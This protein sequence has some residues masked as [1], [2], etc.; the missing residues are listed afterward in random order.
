MLSKFL[1]VLCGL[2][3]A[4]AVNVYLY[5]PQISLR[6][7]LALEDASAALSRHLGLEIFEAFRDSSVLDYGEES[8]VGQGTNNV[9]LLT[10]E[11]VDAKAIRIPS[12][13]QPSFK[14]PTPPSASISS[15]SSVISTYLH[16][17]QHAYTSIY[18]ADPSSQTRKAWYIAELDSITSFFD[19]AQ[20]TSFAA[21]ELS[22][23]ANIRKANGIDSD[24]YRSA[25][26]VTRKLLEHAI[27][28]DTR[29][30][31]LTFSPSHTEAKRAEPSQA[32]FPRPPPQS[33]IDSISTCHTTLDA[34]TNATS[35]CSGRGECAS[36]TKSGKTCFVCAC[37]TTRTG[38]G[39][40]VKTDTWVGESCERKD[41][42][43]PFVLLAG[44]TIVLILIIAGSVSLLYTVGSVELPSVLMG[45][46]INAKK[47]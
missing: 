31:M 32:P 4:Q 19:K 8:F 20:G 39:N 3:A 11:D 7:N 47:D 18:S 24:E 10:L 17:A 43:A 34:C 28:H 13:L 42:S 5:P 37:G 2:R 29:I 1:V 22:G 46:A 16:R 15:L 30:A 35:S 26:E 14:L 40:Q 33:P 25:L 9:L 12:S 45:S 41:I 23:L 6:P 21:A 36:A 44:T 38:S 27:D